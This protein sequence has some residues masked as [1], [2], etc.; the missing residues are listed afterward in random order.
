[1][2]DRG[3]GDGVSGGWR[4][5]IDLPLGFLGHLN[6]DL[7]TTF[8]GDLVL[9]FGALFA[10]C[11][12]CHGELVRLRPA[13]RHLDRVLP[14]DRRGRS[15]RRHFRQPHRAAYFQII[16]GME[17]R[18]GRFVRGGA[19]GVADRR[20][21]AAARHAE[22][23]RSGRPNACRLAELPYRLCCLVGLCFVAAWQ[24]DDAAPARTRYIVREIS[25]A[26]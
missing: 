18:I 25:T 10:I 21:M 2:G 11:M 1:M 12:V 26:W 3:R 13:P 16:F 23:F 20:R 22:G 9:Y 5:E 24:W 17:L 19:C 14:D 8:A 4:T 7:S 15:D 6:F